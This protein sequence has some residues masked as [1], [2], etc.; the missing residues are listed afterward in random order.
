MQ[1]N[2]KSEVETP[3]D[4]DDGTK[5]FETSQSQDLRLGPRIQE[6]GLCCATCK[7]DRA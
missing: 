2:L 4:I 1:G 5:K 3:V 6:A 7:T